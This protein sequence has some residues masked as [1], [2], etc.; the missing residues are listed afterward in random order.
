MKTKI[1]LALLFAFTFLFQCDSDSDN[2]NGSVDLGKVGNQW[3]GTSTGG[4]PIKAKIISNIDDVVTVQ[5]TLNGE[6]NEYKVKVTKD[7]LS[8]FVYSGGDVNKPFTLIN[9][10]DNVG[11]IYEYNFGNIHAQREIVNIGETYYYDAIGKSVATT[12]VY[13]VIPEEINSTILGYTIRTIEWY[14]SPIY[15]IVCVDIYTEDGEYINLE[16]DTMPH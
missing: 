2:E 14:I 16:F 8:D 15:G 1:L 13:E 12:A 11:K 9:F 10:N 4:T 5:V 3:E 7:E 6:V